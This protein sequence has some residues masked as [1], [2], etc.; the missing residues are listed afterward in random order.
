MKF[1][2]ENSSNVSLKTKL[3]NDSGMY[4]RKEEDYYCAVDLLKRF[5]DDLED[6]GFSRMI[7]KTPAKATNNKKQRKFNL[8]LAESENDKKYQ[9]YS[10]NLGPGLIMELKEL[11]NANYL[12]F[13]KY[14]DGQEIHNCFNIP[15][16]QLI[17]LKKAIEAMEIHI[18]SH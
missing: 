15:K 11:R 8:N 18:D 5:T 2:Q 3:S 14:G 13:V 1:Q 7:S 6:D 12:G 10:I 4:N 16:D 9:P 17:V